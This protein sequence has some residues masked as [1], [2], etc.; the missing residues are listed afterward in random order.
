[1]RELRERIAGMRKWRKEVERS[2][3]WMREE[4]WRVER[5]MGRKEEKEGVLEEEEEGVDGDL[6]NGKEKEGTGKRV[7]WSRIR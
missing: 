1:M 5:A 2:V 3:V 4:R 7:R 6:G